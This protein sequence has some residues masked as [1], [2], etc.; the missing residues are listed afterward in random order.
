MGKISRRGYEQ[1]DAL[2][3]SNGN[4]WVQ[5]IL[6]ERLSAGESPYDIARGVFGLPWHVLR[7]W[8]ELNCP[9]AVALAGRAR[10]D[11]LEWE[12]TN[13]VMCADA[14]TLGVAKLQA[15]HYMKLAAK[16]DRSKWG[17][18]AEVGGGGITVVVQR[19]GVLQI[20]DGQDKGYQEK[21][22]IEGDVL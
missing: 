15:D 1:L 9:E 10:A 4:E 12:A 11:M 18:K 20:G 17:D 13:A 8:I 6:M 19:G 2:V 21:E 14:N 7:G 3:A 22:V 16:L 5:D